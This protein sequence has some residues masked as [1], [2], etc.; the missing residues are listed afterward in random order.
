MVVGGWGDQ[1]SSTDRWINDTGPGQ[2]NKLVSIAV[3]SFF[4]VGHCHL[5]IVDRPFVLFSLKTVLYSLLRS[6]GGGIGTG[7]MTGLIKMIYYM[8]YFGPIYHTTKS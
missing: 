5:E 4:K 7:R 1:N 6:A 8:G 2:F 3:W